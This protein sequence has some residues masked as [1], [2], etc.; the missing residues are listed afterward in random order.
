MWFFADQAAS[1]TVDFIVDGEFVVPSSASYSLR[2]HDGSMDSDLVSMTISSPST[3]AVIEIPAVKNSL[4]AGSL[5]ENRFLMV[6]FVH[7]GRTHTRVLPYKVTNFVPMT[8]T[9]DDVRRLTGLTANELPDRDID[10]NTAYFALFDAYGT[11]FSNQL[12][13]TTFRG[14][15]ANEA[16]ALQAAVDVV[17]SFPMRVPV[18]VK[19]EDSQFARIAKLD[20]GALE[21]ELR[22]KLQQALTTVISVAET[23]PDVF[24]VT[25]PTDP[26]TG[27]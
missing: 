6:V 19:A 13:S 3:S 24:S 2:L 17:V 21:K 7:Q 12:L 8:A 14:R 26:F 22:R 16:V 23:T 27:A 25:T 9:A 20:F 1:L 18:S 10:L 11:D 5:L 4:T 15:A